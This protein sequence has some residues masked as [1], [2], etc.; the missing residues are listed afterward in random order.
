MEDVFAQ[1]D[2]MFLT[3]V[4]Y[5]HGWKRAEGS[6]GSF[7]FLLL[8]QRRQDDRNI[9]LLRDSLLFFVVKPLKD[10]F[11]FSVIGIDIHS[12]YKLHK[13]FPHKSTMSRSFGAPL[14]DDSLASDLINY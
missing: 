2:V 4:H 1:T 5:H 3:F 13:D 6:L 11:V 12:F 8:K 10:D 14:C 7:S 9:S